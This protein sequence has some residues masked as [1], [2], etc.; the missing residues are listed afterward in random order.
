MRHLRFVFLLILV[1]S[2][3]NCEKKTNLLTDQLMLKLLHFILKNCIVIG[4]GI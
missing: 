2:L 3:A 4:D 1:L